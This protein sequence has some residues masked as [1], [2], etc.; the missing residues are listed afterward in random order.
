MTSVPIQQGCADGTLAGVWDGRDDPLTPFLVL[1]S[2]LRRRALAV[3]ACTLIVVTLVAAYTYI[4][5]PKYEASASIRVDDSGSRALSLSA[6]PSEGE[7]P[8][9][10]EILR[11]RALAEDV[12]RSLGLQLR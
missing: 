9:E 5:R 4:A 11:S 10:M 12:V 2:I 8:T 1:W 7:L 6:A 3:L